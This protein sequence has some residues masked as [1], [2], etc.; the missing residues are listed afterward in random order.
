MERYE[1]TSRDVREATAEDWSRWFA[2]DRIQWR[3][4]STLALCSVN[5]DALQNGDHELADKARTTINR[6]NR[7]IEAGR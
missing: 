2:V 1:I 6:R 3:R 7:K 5:V 4:F